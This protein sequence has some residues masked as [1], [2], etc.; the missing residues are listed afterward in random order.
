MIKSLWYLNKLFENRVLTKWFFLRYTYLHCII[1]IPIAKVGD[2][3]DWSKSYILYF[4]LNIFSVLHL[5]R[6][7][8]YV[9]E[10]HT[11]WHIAFMIPYNKLFQ[12][13]VITFSTY[14]K[15]PECKQPFCG[16][17][18]CNC[19]VWDLIFCSTLAGL[20]TVIA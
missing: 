11:R 8:L 13:F 3:E 12:L 14:R 2:I 9:L 10:C 15:L 20:S 17:R 7:Y 5:Q 18:K 19:Y 4:N 16:G 6:T 1:Y